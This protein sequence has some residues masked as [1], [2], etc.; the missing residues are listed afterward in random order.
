MRVLEEAEQKVTL[1][2]DIPISG[3]MHDMRGLKGVWFWHCIES[4]TPCLLFFGITFAPSTHFVCIQE[5]KR[6]CR[7]FWSKDAESAVRKKVADKRRF[8]EEL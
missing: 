6:F 8:D 7:K 4:V 2:H 3:A 5:S 1:E